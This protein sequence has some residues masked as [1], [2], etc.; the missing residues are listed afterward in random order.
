MNWLDLRNV[1]VMAWIYTAIVLLGTGIAYNGSLDNGFVNWDDEIYV[2][3][4][5]YIDKSDGWF[6]RVVS[7][8]FHPITM[9]SLH[10]DYKKPPAGETIPDARPFHRT[11]LIFHL[12]NTLLVFVFVH[13]L[14][15][16]KWFVAVVA[17]VLFGLHP[18]HVESVAWVSERKD[19]LYVFFFLLGLISWFYYRHA[20]SKIAYILALAFFVLSCL[21]KAMAVVFPVV[22]L[23][24]D[25]FEGRILTQKPLL[26]FNL[27]L[28]KLP[29][30]AIA[31]FFGFMAVNVQGGGNFY[32]YFDIEIQEKAIG[33]FDVITYGQRLMFACYGF[34]MYFVKLIWPF[35]LSTFYPY[36]NL[37][38]AGSIKF[39]IMPVLAAVV[40]GGAI[41][42]YKR[43]KVFT[44]SIFFYLVTVAL[45]LQFLSVGKVIMADRYTYL[46]YVGLGVLLGY[47]FQW[48]YSRQ[49]YRIV[50]VAGIAIL[51][52]FW[53]YRTSEA[54]E[55]WKDGESLWTNVI[56]TFPQTHEAYVNRGNNRG[57]NG[58]YQ[59]A[60]EDFLIAVQLKPDE[61]EI[62]KSLGNTYGS[63]D[64]FEKSIEAFDKALALKPGNYT[65]YLNRGVTY[66]RSGNDSMAMRD[67]ELAIA[68][69]A[70]SWERPRI[71]SF[72]SMAAF[73]IK[74]YDKA[75]ATLEELVKLQPDNGDAHRQL[76]EMYHQLGNFPKRDEHVKALQ[77]LGIEIPKSIQ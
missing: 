74:D 76:A 6:K 56:K 57:K 42:M 49:Q 54:C 10:R 16:G 68:N 45:V 38:E 22:L 63:L 3:E 13:L 64:Q 43:S 33:S 26:R 15:K 32:G 18:M 9:M 51:G 72:I 14:T 17:S 30:F 27:I 39:L 41:Y 47:G 77:R 59:K 11:N 5:P 19:V 73:N 24:I 50:A 2:T 25:Y 71:L 29:H 53:G 20:K 46:P 35:G 28:E 65:Y 34:I 36:P 4:N 58:E 60:L 37:Q 40:I 70:P 12:L 44:F 52:I 23:L 75:S 7:L 61:A 21:S 8:N 55:A 62:F 31:L 48:L 69:G 1:P 66:G 67:F